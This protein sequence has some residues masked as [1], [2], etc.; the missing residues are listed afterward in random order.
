MNKLP[1]FFQKNSIVLGVTIALLL[2]FI[3]AAILYPIFMLFVKMGWNAFQL[4]FSKYLIL[5]CAPA[6]FVARYYLKNIQYEKTGKGALFT[7]LILLGLHIFLNHFA[8]Y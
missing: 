4:P 5:G 2:P 7:T 8:I 1:A 3:T 6:L